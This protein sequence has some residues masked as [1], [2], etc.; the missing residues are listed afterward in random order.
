MSTAFPEGGDGKA[1]G[2]LP[3]LP[4]KSPQNQSGEPNSTLQFPSFFQHPNPL[5]KGDL[6]TPEIEAATVCPLAWKP[7]GQDALIE[8]R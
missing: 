5:L 4:P 2:L 6:L 7:C 1:N 8:P 3:N